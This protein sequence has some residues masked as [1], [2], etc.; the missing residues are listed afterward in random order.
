M[1]AT[2]ITFRGFVNNFFLLPAPISCFSV[3]LSNEK[4][5]LCLQV[6]QELRF[7]IVHEIM[8]GIFLEVLYSNF[9][10]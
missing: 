1:F 3:F 10:K 6:D 5:L 2:K 8:I 7:Y 4:L 9:V